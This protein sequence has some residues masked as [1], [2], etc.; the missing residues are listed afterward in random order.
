MGKGGYSKV[1][2]G[3]LPDGKMIIVKRVAKKNT[4][5]RKE[6]EFLTELGIIGHLCHANTT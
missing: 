5:E 4:N 6:K 2:K 3:V 1:Y